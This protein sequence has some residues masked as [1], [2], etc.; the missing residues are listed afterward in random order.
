MLACLAEKDREAAE[1]KSRIN[2]L[3][4]KMEERDLVRRTKKQHV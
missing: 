3:L 2:E 4:S 1:L